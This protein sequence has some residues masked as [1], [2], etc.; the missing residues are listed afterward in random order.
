MSTPEDNELLRMD[1]WPGGVNNRVRETEQMV[2]REERTIPSSQFLRKALNVD[3]TAEGHP[4]RRRGYEL[5]QSGY[6]HSVWACQQLGIICVV[7][8]GE[9]M[10]G[11]DVESLV[12]MA[13]VN[14]YQ[15]VSYA[16]VNDSIYWSNGQQLGEITYALESRAWGIPSGPQPTLAGPAAANPGGWTDTRQVSIVYEDS[17]GREGGASEPIIVGSSGSFSVSIPLPL[18]EGVTGAKVYVGQTNSEILYYCRTI[19]SSSPPLVMVHESEMGQGKELD[20]LSMKP[21]LAGQLVRSMNGRVYIARNSKILFTEPLRYHLTRPSQ[22]IFMMPEYITL[23]E[24]STDGLY[25]GTSM[26]VVFIAGSDPYDVRQTH[27]SPYAPVEGAVSRV[28]GE[29]F[30]VEVDEVPVWWGADGVMVVGLPGGQLR[31]LT[32]D[33]LAVPKF[34]AGSVTLREEEGMSHIVSSLRSSDGISRMGASDSVVAEVRT[35]NIVL[36]S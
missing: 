11:R 36:N 32:R 21:P 22:G 35:N 33:R 20:T 6:S 4:I 13:T 8:N 9:L 7:I 15:P 26:G 12:S 19:Y 1:G 24:P 5:V 25:V 10:A 28:P 17:T 18:P 23:M 27:V 30:G 29:K 2:S 3:L 31:Q 34:Q 16:F 14:R